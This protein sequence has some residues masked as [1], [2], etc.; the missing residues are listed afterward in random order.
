MLSKSTCYA[1][2]D[3]SYVKSVAYNRKI[4]YV[5]RKPDGK[6]PSE[7]RADGKVSIKM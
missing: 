2:K 1:N 7:R 3:T 6:K 5:C 4:S